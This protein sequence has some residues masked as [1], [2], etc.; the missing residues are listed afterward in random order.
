MRY[1]SGYIYCGDDAALR[2]D[3]ATHAW[4]EVAIPGKGWIGFDPTNYVLVNEHHIRV[5]V[6]RDYTDVT[7]PK[8]TYRGG[9][10]L[11]EVKVVV[12]PI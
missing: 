5:A 4:V 7:P 6:G 2:G 10:Q 1:V 8:G 12:K 3:A 11:L 9:N